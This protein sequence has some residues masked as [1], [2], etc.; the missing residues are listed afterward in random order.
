MKSVKLSKKQG[1][2]FFIII[3]L[4]NQILLLKKLRQIKIIVLFFSFYFCYIYPFSLEKTQ[5]LYSYEKSEMNRKEKLAQT[6]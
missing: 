4:S 5:K 3:V 2:A 6:T 1:S